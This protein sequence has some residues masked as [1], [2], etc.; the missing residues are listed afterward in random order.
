MIKILL[1]NVFVALLTA[2]CMFWLFR[3]YWVPS[4]KSNAEPAAEPV[5]ATFHEPPGGKVSHTWPATQLPD[6]R[7]VA[8]QAMP[9]VVH[10]TT[11]SATGYK[12]SSGSGVIISEDGYIATNQHVIEDGSRVSVQL[13]DRRSFTAEVVG[14]DRSTDMALLKV[15]APK[16]PYLTLGDSDQ[17]VVGEWVL[18]VG[19]PFG[20]S[21]TV[22]VGIVSAKTRN[23]N[24]L[25]GA[26]AIES[27]IQTDAAINAGNSGGA[28][29][30]LQGQLIGINAAI[31][32]ESGRFEG[33]S[34][35]IPVNLAR[36]V[37]TDLREYG[38]VRRAVLGIGI[39]EMDSDMAE[40][41][42]L[43]GVYGVVLSSVTQGGSA[44]TAGLQ[45]GDVI[46]NIDGVKVNS[47][48]ELQERVAMYRPGDR[49]SIGYVRDGQAMTKDNVLLLKPEK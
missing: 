13:S 12:I 5:L 14:G 32:S 39:A 9:A 10:V 15:A 48:P 45:P 3:H 43:A 21:S 46:V 34:F 1:S 30:N 7:Q 4:N 19:N 17:T 33:Y 49:V 35:A 27:F 40:Q 23:I 44:A 16:L 2:V 22:T 36:K 20:L 18:A 29:V 11:W 28:L 47:V 41:K 37:A 42:G 6:L 31:L 24:I 8:A 38:E 25:K 26:Y